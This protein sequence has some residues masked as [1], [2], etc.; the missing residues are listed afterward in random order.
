MLSADGGNTAEEKSRTEDTEGTRFGKTVLS[1]QLLV[2]SCQW[3]KKLSV[4]EWDRRFLPWPMPCCAN[5][6][7]RAEE[8]SPGGHG[9]VLRSD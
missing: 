7:D 2:V 3:D 6:G 8:K 4:V 5:G 1:G 9:E